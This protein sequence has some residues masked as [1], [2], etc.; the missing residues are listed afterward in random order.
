[1]RQPDENKI[2]LK[3]Q[4]QRT[5]LLDVGDVELVSKL[6]TETIKEHGFNVHNARTI[7]NTVSIEAIYGPRFTSFIV[8]VIPFIGR[9]LPFG[10][11]LGLRA[12]II[13]DNTI[14]VQINISP[15]MELFDTSEVLVLSQTVDEKLTDEYF[16]AKK[17]HDIT[18]QL[19]ESLNL[20]IP[21]KFLK[22]NQRLHLSDTF[23][24]TLIY[25]LDGYKAKKEI[26]IPPSKGPRWSWPA[27][28]I[29]ELWFM[30][31]EIWG[32]SLL[33]VALEFA[34]LRLVE[35]FKGYFLLFYP[36]LFF[37]IRIVV[38]IFANRIYFYRYGHWIKY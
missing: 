13:Q 19:Y 15:Y 14:K 5:V 18:V 32:V 22:F 25:P 36:V 1:M 6:F 23:L 35:V 27:F 11:R 4:L 38:A 30:W 29:P 20:P 33:V 3:E 12:S 37:S 10:K 16:A 7:D 21:D 17:I 31:H 9:H 2:D 28:I 24:S 26:H 8:S 34:A